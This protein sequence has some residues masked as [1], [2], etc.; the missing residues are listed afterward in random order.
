MRFAGKNRIEIKIS[1]ILTLDSCGMEP[2]TEHRSDREDTQCF[3]QQK[4]HLLIF[5]AWT[6]LSYEI[7]IY[8]PHFSLKELIS[9]V[10]TDLFKERFHLSKQTKSAFDRCNARKQ[11]RSNFPCLGNDLFRGKM[12]TFFFDQGTRIIIAY[13]SKCL[14]KHEY[15]WTNLG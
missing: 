5:M 10:M 9:L 7:C 2:N 8:S 4:L 3:F 6:F 15:Q 13:S 14:N 12:H 11:G 1:I